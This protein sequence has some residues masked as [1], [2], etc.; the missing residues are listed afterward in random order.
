[1]LA[2]HLTRREKMAMLVDAIIAKVSA[3]PTNFEVIIN[4]L[5]N[6]P[7]HHSVAKLLLQSYG[8]IFY[9]V[10]YRVEV[11]PRSGMGHEYRR[12]PKRVS[13]VISNPIMVT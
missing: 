4:V 6:R 5:E 11:V 7:P 1:M 12:T 9:S 2:D 13:Q 10:Y 3:N 8:E